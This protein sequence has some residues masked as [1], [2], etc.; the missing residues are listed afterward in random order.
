MTLATFA[1]TLA[2]IAFCRAFAIGTNACAKG[3][4]DQS[5]DAMLAFACATTM[6]LEQGH[7]GIDTC[8]CATSTTMVAPY[9]I[10]C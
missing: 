3:C 9:I 6:A 4:G 5:V 10:G 1:R 8:T 2:V 7:I